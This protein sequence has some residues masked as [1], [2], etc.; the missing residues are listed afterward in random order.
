[1]EAECQRALQDFQTLAQ[2]DQE[3]AQQADQL[4]NTVL[5]VGWPLQHALLHD[6]LY[7]CN[8]CVCWVCVVALPLQNSW[9][10]MQGLAY[11]S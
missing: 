5:Q 9:C 6:V 4:L 2:W 11:A 3:A 10:S 7:V 1:M 8:C